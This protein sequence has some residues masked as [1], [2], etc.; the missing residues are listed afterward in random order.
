MDNELLVMTGSIMVPNW[1]INHKVIWYTERYRQYIK[2]I[3]YY[4]VFSDFYDIVFVDGNEFDMKKMKYLEELAKE[5]WKNLELISFKNNQDL[6]L[7][8]WKGY[9]EHKILEYFIKHSTLLKKHKS[10]FKVTGR[11]IIKNINKIL[12]NEKGKETCFFRWYGGW[13]FHCNTAFFKCS[14][15]FFDDFLIWLAEEVDEKKWILLEHVYYNKL[16]EIKFKSR[17]RELPIFS[18]QFWIWGKLDRWK[19][20]ILIKNILN[21]LWF[22]NM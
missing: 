19:V 10:F 22:F 13:K 4:I 11:Y 18:W 1:L 17:F 12:L 7:K 14:V 8:K 5:Y 20:S 6:I 2:A 16:K 15:D 9:W 3:T 21:M